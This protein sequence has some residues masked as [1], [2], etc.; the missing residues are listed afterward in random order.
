MLTLSVLIDCMTGCMVLTFTITWYS[1][2]GTI[3][4]ALYHFFTWD[5][6]SWNKTIDFLLKFYSSCKWCKYDRLFHWKIL[7]VETFCSKSRNELFR[8]LLWTHFSN[9]TFQSVCVTVFLSHFP[10]ILLIQPREYNKKWQKYVPRCYIFS[11]SLFL[12][13]NEYKDF[14]LLPIIMAIVTSNKDPNVSFITF[15]ILMM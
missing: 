8:P 4:T 7:Q 15:M 2:W 10:T 5:I 14:V 12:G 1:I 3:L 9:F 11:F 13:S 6:L